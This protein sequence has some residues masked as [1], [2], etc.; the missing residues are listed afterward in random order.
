MYFLVRISEP[1]LKFF[2]TSVKDNGR[3][4]ARISEEAGWGVSEGVG[5]ELK[6]QVQQLLLHMHELGAEQQDK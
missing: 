2:E 6:A 4:G 1:G 5:G 3:P